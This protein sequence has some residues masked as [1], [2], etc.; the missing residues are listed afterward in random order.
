MDMRIIGH[1]IDIVE[2]ERIAHMLDRHGRRFL[3]RCFTELERSYLNDNPRRYVEHLAGRF[4]AKEAVLKVLGTGFSNGV[5]WT[6]IEVRREITGRPVLSIGGR[7]AELASQR[8]ICEWWIS[9][10]HIRSHALAS[11]IGVG[12]D[13]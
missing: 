1:G 9:I 6:E 12:N 4:A 3:D 11:V 10:S 8:G 5:A 2:T 7:C 13:V